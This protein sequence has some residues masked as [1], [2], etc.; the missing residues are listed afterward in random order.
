LRRVRD[1]LNRSDANVSGV[2]INDH[3]ASKAG[4]YGG[5]GYG[6]YK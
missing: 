6:Y 5:Y 2:V 4:Y 3:P 1:V